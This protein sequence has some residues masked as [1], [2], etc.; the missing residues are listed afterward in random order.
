MQS[1]TE[2]LLKKMLLEQQ[3]QTKLLAR[4]AKQ[5]STTIY[6]SEEM[7]DISRIANEV[8]SRIVRGLEDEK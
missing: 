3:K 7:P 8:E 2:K 5:Q 1:N 4:I 6:V